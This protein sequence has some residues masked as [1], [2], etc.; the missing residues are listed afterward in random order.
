SNSLP[1]DGRADDI[2]PSPGIHRP[3]FASLAD[4]GR[5][6][7]HSGDGHQ[8]RPWLRRAYSA[9]PQSGPRIGRRLLLGGNYGHVFLGR[10]EGE[11]GG[12][13]DGP[14]ATGRAGAIL[15]ADADAGVSDAD[16]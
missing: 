3:P 8:L 9:G 7:T 11:P 13:A 12:G 15:A 16:E 10:S 6:R 14:D 2:R 5:I 1:E 4:P